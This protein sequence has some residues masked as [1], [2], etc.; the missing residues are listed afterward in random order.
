MH[1]LMYNTPL[2]TSVASPALYTALR[3]FLLLPQYLLYISP[4]EGKILS[5]H[6]SHIHLPLFLSFSL[7]NGLN[8]SR[9]PVIDPWKLFLFWP[10]LDL[11]EALTE[12]LSLSPGEKQIHSVCMSTALNRGPQTNT[13]GAARTRNIRHGRL[14]ENRPLKPHYSLLCQEGVNPAKTE[15]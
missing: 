9:N 12:V 4:K 14:A 6:A 15:H 3:S 1:L 5:L 2:K 8:N 13:E 11:T 10:A 7:S